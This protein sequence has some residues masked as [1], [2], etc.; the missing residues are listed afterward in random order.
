MPSKS[1]AKG[2][3]FERQIVDRAKHF[4]LKAKRAWGSDGRAMGQHEEVDVVIG[5]NLRVQAKCRKKIA[6]WMIPNENVDIQV[7][8]GDR[9][10]PLAVMPLDFFLILYKLSDHTWSN[11]KYK[12]KE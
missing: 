9:E 5:D 3:R 2:N 4:D 12:D 11:D 10:I 6:Q 1:K 8:K 7:V